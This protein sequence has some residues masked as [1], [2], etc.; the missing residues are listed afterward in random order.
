MGKTSFS[1]PAFGAKA[2]LLSVGP[3]AASTGS[4]AVF[5]GTIVPA[6]EDWYLTEV[7]LHRNS[8]GSTNFVVSVHDDST[9]VG[10]VGV[11]GSSIAASGIARFTPDVGEFQGVKVLSGSTITLSHSSHAGPNI[12]LTAV[13]S[14]YRRF[15]PSTVYRD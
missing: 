4:S 6:G 5:A 9:L 13:L 11:G 1:G 2:T 10:S 8:T 3:L 15:V 14:G 12:N 7:A